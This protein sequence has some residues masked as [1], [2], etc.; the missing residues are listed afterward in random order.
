MRDREPAL[1][2]QRGGD[3][4]LQPGIVEGYLVQVGIGALAA[5]EG[6]RTVLGPELAKPLSGF[7]QRNFA[8]I[9]SATWEVPTAVG[10]SRSFFMS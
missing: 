7:D 6:S 9:A 3:D 5:R 1:A 4:G 2:R 8:M 10:S